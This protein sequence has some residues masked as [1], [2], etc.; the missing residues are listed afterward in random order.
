VLDL[1]QV[2][3][4][5]QDFGLTTGGQ[6]VTITGSDFV[7][8]GAKAIAVDFGGVAALS[9]TVIDNHTIDATAP[10]GTGTVDVTVTTGAGAS[11]AQPPVDSFYYLNSFS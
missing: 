7:Y 9:F 3:S 10:P 8:K 6:A 2:T 11:S 4:V 1:P 5:A